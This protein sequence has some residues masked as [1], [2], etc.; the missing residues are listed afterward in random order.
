MS[1]SPVKTDSM[2]QQRTEVKLVVRDD[3]IG[4]VVKEGGPSKLGLGIM[5]ERAAA[6][7]GNLSLESQAGK[8]TTVTLTW[9]TDTGETI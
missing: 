1:A 2:D 6:I 3:G 7:H 4:L 9:L 5:R 8:G